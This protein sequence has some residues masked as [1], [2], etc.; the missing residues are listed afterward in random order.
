MS[1]CVLNVLLSLCKDQP[2]RD[3][4]PV[5]FAFSGSGCTELS[6]AGC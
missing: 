6:P 1:P 3:L 5:R 2:E 4:I